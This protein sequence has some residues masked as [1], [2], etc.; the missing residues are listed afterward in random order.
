MTVREYTILTDIERREVM[1]ISCFIGSRADEAGMM[2]IHGHLPNDIRRLVTSE[3]DMEGIAVL[4]GD[5]YEV[6]RCAL[7]CREQ[8]IPI[9]HV[10]AGD[11]TGQEPDDTYREVITRLATWRFCANSQAAKQLQIKGYRANA[12][13]S[14]SPYISSVVMTNISNVIWPEGKRI[15]VC[16]NPLPESE[17]ETAAIASAL[18]KLPEHGYV[19]LAANTDRYAWLINTA[20]KK[21]GEFH[22]RISHEEYLGYMQSADVIIGNTSAGL[23]ENSFFGTPYIC[24]GS[25]QAGRVGGE[26]VIWCEKIDRLGDCLE[27]A[28]EQPKRPGNSYGDEHGALRIARMLREKA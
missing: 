11:V 8:L 23:I 14:G 21:M 22:D 17:S 9:A 3:D 13:I 16:C 10:H 27:Y 6:A 5:R 18:L 20:A 19:T 12:Y 2:A 24:V 25:R 26:H 28:L 15:F 7:Y 1:K 4:I